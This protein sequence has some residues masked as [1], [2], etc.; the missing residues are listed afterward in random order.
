MSKCQP[1]LDINS[2]SF[3]NM[4][5]NI[6]TLKIVWSTIDPCRIVCARGMQSVNYQVRHLLRFEI[7]GTEPESG[8]WAVQLGCVYGCEAW[9]GRSGHAPLHALP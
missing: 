9:N 5:T 7:G 6:C 1:I 3:S 8:T 4:F 2:Y